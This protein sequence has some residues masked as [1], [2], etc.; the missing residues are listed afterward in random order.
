MSK[1][2]FR[3]PKIFEIRGGEGDLAVSLIHFVN[4]FIL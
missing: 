2:P 4:P 1:R 3:Q